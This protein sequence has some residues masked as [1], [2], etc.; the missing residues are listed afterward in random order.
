MRLYI[1]GLTALAFARLTIGIGHASPAAVPTVGSVHI[2][3]VE[4]G[5]VPPGTPLL[6]RTNEVVSTDRASPTAI[7]GGQVAEAVQDQN[8]NVLV[9]SM[10]PVEL[11]VNQVTFLGPGGVGMWELVLDIRAMTVKGV[12]YEVETAEGTSKGAGFEPQGAAAITAEGPT[13]HVFTSGRRINVPAGTTLKFQ[14]AEPIRLRDYQAFQF[15][16]DP[17]ARWKES[18]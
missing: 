8:G 5:V 17:F 6:V 12:R 9:P 2:V 10:S 18:R 11:A 3:T 4:S 14:T 15:P 16:A 7:Y 13:R 1:V